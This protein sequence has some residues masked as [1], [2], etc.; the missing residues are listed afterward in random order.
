MPLR[1]IGHGSACP[2]VFVKELTVGRVCLV[3]VVAVAKSSDVAGAC[4]PF[5]HAYAEM[6]CEK[7]E[8]KVPLLATTDGIISAMGQAPD[9]PRLPGPW[10]L[11]SG[12]PERSV[13]FPRDGQH[14]SKPHLMASEW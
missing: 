8:T 12:S 13:R 4:L 11:Q 9:D 2:Y 14:V 6:A 3:G 1:S 5:G 10:L 7:V